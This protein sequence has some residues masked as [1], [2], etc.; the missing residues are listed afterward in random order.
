MNSHF[1]VLAAA[2]GIALGGLVSAVNEVL[3]FVAVVTAACTGTARYIA[4]LLHKEQAEVEQATAR[5]FVLGIA[6]SALF[7]L[8]EHL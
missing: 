7:L 4:V 6:L 5:G 1:A 2:L 8:V 3:S